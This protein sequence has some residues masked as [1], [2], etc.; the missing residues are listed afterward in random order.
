[1]EFDHKLKNHQTCN[2]LRMLG[3]PPNSFQRYLKQERLELYEYYADGETIEEFILYKDL[4]MIV[5]KPGDGI[6]TGFGKTY[7]P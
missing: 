2:C 3:T 4:R 6:P 1:M 7:S 5:L